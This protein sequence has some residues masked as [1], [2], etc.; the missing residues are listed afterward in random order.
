MRVVDVD[1]LSRD[2]KLDLIDELW[3]SLDADAG[4]LSSE[5]QAEIDRRIAES[6]REPGIP[7]SEVKA[8]ARQEQR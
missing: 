8:R 1:A 7:W 6:E 2:E 4:C 5:L 3:E